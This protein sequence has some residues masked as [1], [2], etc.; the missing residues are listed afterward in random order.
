MA[1]DKVQKATLGG[2]T[3]AEKK[4]NYEG[5]DG[6]PGHN[7]T[8]NPLPQ[9]AVEVE[10]EDEKEEDEMKE[11]GKMKKSAV[12]AA[13]EQL[14]SKLAAGASVDEIN[15]AFASLGTE[16]EKSYVPKSQPMDMSNLAEIVKSAVE[17]AV[18]PL[19][20]EIAQLKAG[21]TVS[22]SV[23]GQVPMPRSLTLKQS[24][25]MQKAQVANAPTRKLS[26]IEMIARRS[27]GAPLP[28]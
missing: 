17:S 11:E 16:V 1:Q 7:V 27:T 12:D 2:E 28:E 20:I 19:K 8:A 22:K 3:V 24:D 13:Y 14:K 6:D 5:I 10:I 25:L 23:T 18:A 9:K 26:Q 21:N 15:A 4:F